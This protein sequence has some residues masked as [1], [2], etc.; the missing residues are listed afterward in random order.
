MQ[1]SFEEELQKLKDAMTVE[2]AMSERY[3]QRQ[4]EHQA[5]IEANEAAIAYHRSWL[6]ELDVRLDRIS[7]L[8]EGKI[9]G[10]NGN[11]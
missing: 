4:R 8:L 6:V 11:Q 7:R 9:R 2:M 10:E 3:R 5:W 1:P